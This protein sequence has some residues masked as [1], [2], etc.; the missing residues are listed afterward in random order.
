MMV[1]LDIVGADKR[2]VDVAGVV[3]AASGIRWWH[4]AIAALL[5]GAALGA[6]S[7]VSKH[8]VRKAFKWK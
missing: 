5:G 4:V 2:S 1:G 6:T 8:F 3:A 7:A